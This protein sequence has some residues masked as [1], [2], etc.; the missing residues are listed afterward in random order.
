M[1]WLHNGYLITIKITSKKY[2][3]VETLPTSRRMI[4]EA[5]SIPLRHKYLTTDSPG[6][7]QASGRV[8]LVLQAQTFPLSEMMWS[9]KCFPH[10]SKMPIFTY[11]YFK[12][13]L[14]MSIVKKDML[15]CYLILKSVKFCS[16][17]IIHN[18]PLSSPKKIKIKANNV[19]PVVIPLWGSFYV[20]VMEIFV[21]YFFFLIKI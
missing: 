10:V 2:H 21:L 11:K 14:Y 7:V 3:T 8:K 6:L 18:P 15:D 20:I 16:N 17:F 5:K 19:L 1:I 9:Y 13:K 12:N 4:V